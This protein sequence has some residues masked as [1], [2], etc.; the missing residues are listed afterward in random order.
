MKKETGLEYLWLALYAF[1]SVYL[2]VNRDV[3]KA[4]SI[5]FIMFAL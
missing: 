5:L 4:F 2:L 1:G 3:R